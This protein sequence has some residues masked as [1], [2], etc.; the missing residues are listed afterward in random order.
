MAFLS[1]GREC[2]IPGPRS[3]GK[4]PYLYA[5]SW[6]LLSLFA[7]P[8]RSPDVAVMHTPRHSFPERGGHVGEHGSLDVIQSR[9]P[10]LLSGKGVATRGLVDAHARLVDGGQG[11]GIRGLHRRYVDGD[12]GD[13]SRRP[14]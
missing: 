13:M 3:S 7:D 6:I 14:S 9:A 4:S 11:P 1:Y 5:A 2:A 12:R 8:T 10:L